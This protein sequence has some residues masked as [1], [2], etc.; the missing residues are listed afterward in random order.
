MIY[1]W[2]PFYEFI[3]QMHYLRHIHVKGALTFG[4]P[5]QTIDPHSNSPY[6]SLFSLTVVLNGMVDDTR[7]GSTRVKR[8]VTT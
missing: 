8:S 7:P 6:R 4:V 5:Y 1:L 3:I 2:L